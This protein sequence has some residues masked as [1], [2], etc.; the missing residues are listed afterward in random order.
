M[1]GPCGGDLGFAIQSFAP[2]LPW[3]VR[4]LFRLLAGDL[5]VLD[6][7][8]KDYLLTRN[9]VTTDIAQQV[10]TTPAQGYDAC[11]Q[12]GVVNPLALFSYGANQVSG[13][14]MTVKWNR[15]FS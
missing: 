10:V 7:G 4:V 14:S 12:A 9:G 15:L 11:V 13:G 6:F 3:V 8:A 5:L 2:G 1:T